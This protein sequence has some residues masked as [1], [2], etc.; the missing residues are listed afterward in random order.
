[1]PIA[2]VGDREERGTSTRRPTKP[3]TTTVTTVKPVFR[4]NVRPLTTNQKL[5]LT[6]V[7]TRQPTTTT[8]RSTASSKSGSGSSKSGSSGG[9]RS[10]G[11][12]GGSSSGG[13]GGG[14]GGG[15]VTPPVLTPGVD[16]YLPIAADLYTDSPEAMFADIIAQRYPGDTGNAIFEMVKP[17]AQMANVLFLAERG[18]TAGGGTKDEY[19]GWMSDFINRL[20]TQGAS[21]T[22]PAAMQNIMAPAEGS[23]LQAYLATGDPIEN[24]DNFQRLAAAGLQTNYHK[25]MARAMMDQVERDALRYVGRSGREVLDPFY[26]YVQG[27]PIAPS[28]RPRV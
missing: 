7:V 18:N 26:K 25:L 5:Q 17:Y 20:L 27:L 11:G 1:M 4:P 21:P 22:N 23:P 10:S 2:Y 13:G 15:S 19:I 28:L 16:G 12:G 24:S 3:K 6:S 9:S 8:S 14:G